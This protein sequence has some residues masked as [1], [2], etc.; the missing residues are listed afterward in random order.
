MH[1]TGAGHGVRTGIKTLKNIGPGKRPF[2]PLAAKRAW[3]P[4]LSLAKNLIHP[5]ESSYWVALKPF[6][7]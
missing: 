7:V 4:I 1:V 6:E 5:G 3:T 2:Q